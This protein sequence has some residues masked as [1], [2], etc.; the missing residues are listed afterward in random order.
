VDAKTE[1]GS[2]TTT[3]RRMHS[4]EQSASTYTGTA[5]HSRR[6]V[7]TLFAWADGRVEV[8]LRDGRVAKLSLDKHRF[9]WFLEPAY[10]YSFGRGHQQSVG[11]SARLLFVLH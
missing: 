7:A 2:D 3:T 4:K 9:G 8:H 6:Y 10:D 5:R 11:M 1:N